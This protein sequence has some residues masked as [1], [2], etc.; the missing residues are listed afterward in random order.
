M[1]L[2]KRLRTQGGF[3]V[4]AAGTPAPHSGF[5]VSREGTER[6]IPGFAKPQDIDAFQTEHADRLQHPGYYMGGWRDGDKTYLDISQRFPTRESAM[7][8]GGVHHQIAA[9]DAAHNA[10]PRVDP[11]LPF[12]DERKL[13]IEDV[14]PSHWLENQ[15]HEQPLAAQSHVPLQQMQFGL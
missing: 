7:V 3:S 1:A 6:V 8:Q 14:P 12:P 11:I 5:T 13:D 9:F 15:P 10:Y 2:A 4:S